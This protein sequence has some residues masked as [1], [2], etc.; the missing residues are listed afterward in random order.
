MKGAVVQKSVR[1]K[2]V[3]PPPPILAAKSGPPPPT[4]DCQNWSPLANSGYTYTT[5][6]S[7][8]NWSG[9]PFL[10]A[11]SGSPYPIGLLRLVLLP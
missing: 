6:F 1:A 2:S 9:G 10:A 8:Q 11:K 3:P 5:K 7:N 4:F